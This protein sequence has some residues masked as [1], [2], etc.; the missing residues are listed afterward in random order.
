MGEIVTVKNQAT[1]ENYLKVDEHNTVSSIKLY[2]FLK[3]PPDNYNQWCKKNIEDNPFAFIGEDYA[4]Y[5]TYEE[6]GKKKI[7]IYRLSVEFARKLSVLSDSNYRY[8][9]FHYFNRILDEL[10]PSELSTVNHYETIDSRE[11]A[12]MIGKRHDHLIRDIQKYCEVLGAPNFGDSE[13]NFK[14]EDSAGETKN[15][16]SDF[17]IESNYISEQN[18]KLPCYLL[19]R[20]GC[21]FVANK[22][23]GE[24]G[25]KFTAAYINKFHEMEKTLQSPTKFK[26]IESNFD[27]KTTEIKIRLSNQYLKLSKLS[28]LSQEE[29][30]ANQVTINN[31]QLTVG[32]N[33]V[34]PNNSGANGLK[35][36]TI[37]AVIIQRNWNGDGKDRVMDCG[38]FEID[39]LGSNG[40]A[41]RGSTVTLKCT[42][43]PNSSTVRTQEKSR[44]WENIKL[45]SIAAQIAKTNGMDIMFISDFDPVYERREQVLESD[46]S[47]LSGLCYNA[48]ISLK[49]TS[50]I[51]VLFDAT[52]FE[53]KPAVRK[54]ERGK[55]DIKSWRFNASTNDANYSRCRVSY[56]NPVTGITIEYT[57]TPRDADPD[58]ITL[59]INEKVSSR[60]EARNLAMR[61]LRQKNK[62]AFSAAFTL[63]GDVSLFAGVC[64]EVVRWGYF[65]GKYIISRNTSSITGSGYTAQLM[66]RRAEDEE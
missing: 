54:I 52:E 9:A 13:G 16:L 24:K 62:E 21:E 49:V 28:A 66:L 38:S 20:K 58:G 61:R 4:N 45:S 5:F 23:T 36:M 47:F 26:Q 59:E 41:D 17:F 22:M 18:K 51:I 65:D 39:D 55:A 33:S 3:L 64:V 60:N 46:I 14:I 2:E 37:S 57:Y 32:A 30:D 56:T 11:V 10:E 48:G 8:A 50:G 27:I 1:I 44:A 29:R 34:S 63:V 12:E 40:G 15:G 42:S 35:G 7:T 43:L 31:E 53:K 25:I 19:T 6:R